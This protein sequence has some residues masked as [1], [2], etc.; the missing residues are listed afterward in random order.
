M[1]VLDSSLRL[2]RVVTQQL[3]QSTPRYVRVS[4]RLVSSP[5]N[6][7]VWLTHCLLRRLILQALECQVSW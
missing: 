6:Q 4:D 7:P 2:A 3:A 1:S 5:A